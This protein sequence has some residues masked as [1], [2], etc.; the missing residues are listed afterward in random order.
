MRNGSGIWVVNHLDSNS[1]RYEGQYK[2]DKKNGFGIYSWKDGT[3]YEGEFLNDLK[4]GEGVVNYGDG[5]VARLQ[6]FEGAVV[7]REVNKSGAKRAT[8]RNTK[9]EN[10]IIKGLP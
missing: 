8:S 9:N 4:H 3:S 6:W 5:R 1:D 7:P 10:N 2:N